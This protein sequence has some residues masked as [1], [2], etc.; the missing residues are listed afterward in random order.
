MIIIPDI[1]RFPEPPAQDNHP[2]KVSQRDSENEQGNK[3]CP[4][5]RMTRRVEMREDGHD[6]QQISD[7]M[8]PG[9][10][11]ERGGF[12]KIVREKSKQ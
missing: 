12:W 10:A 11:E 8:T 5:P 2:H 1:K 6:S 7:Q 9:I 3:D 4:N